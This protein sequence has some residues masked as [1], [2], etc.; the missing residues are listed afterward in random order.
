[1]SGIKSQVTSSGSALANRGQ[2]REKAITTHKQKVDTTHNVN[3]TPFR[4]TM[5]DISDLDDWVDECQESMKKKVTRAKLL[6]GLI[7]IKDELPP[8]VK[9]LLIDAIKDI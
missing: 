8:E 5:S 7:A 9:E 6:R 3:P 2:K 4:L 1:M